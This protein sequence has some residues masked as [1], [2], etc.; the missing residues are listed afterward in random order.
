MSARVDCTERGMGS[1]LSRPLACLNHL[2][3]AVTPVP[4]CV[5]GTEAV[6]W[7]WPSAWG[8]QPQGKVSAVIPVKYPLFW[9][10]LTSSRGAAELIG[11]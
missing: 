1:F 6:A 4:H 8:P 11:F 7:Q 5:L 10:R 3:V 9:S 2:A